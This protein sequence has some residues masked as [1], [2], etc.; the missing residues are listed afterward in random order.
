MDIV[1]RYF[2]LQPHLDR[3][4]YEIMCLI[5]S[6]VQTKQLKDL[7]VNLSNFQSVTKK[8][9]DP[10]ITMNQVRAIFDGVIEL[11]PVMKSYLI[12]DA[13]IVQNA[14]L[15]QEIVK[16]LDGQEELLTA[17]EK[18]A[19]KPFLLNSDEVELVEEVNKKDKKI[20]FADRLIQTKKRK[21]ETK[22]KYMD[23]SYIPATSNVVDRFFSQCKNVLTDKRQSMYPINFEAVMFLKMNR[24]LWD[25]RLLSKVIAKH[26]YVPAEEE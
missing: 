13:K 20:G 1:R 7:M 26:R 21:L 4:E 18:N 23:M 11:Y 14:T 10:C 22:S 16:V 6:L 24:H 15:E 17:F 12:A 3:D 2:K 5:P 8:L 25:I 9:Q 19:L